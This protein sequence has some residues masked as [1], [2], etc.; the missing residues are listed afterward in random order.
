MRPFRSEDCPTVSAPPEENREG[1][2]VTVVIP[3]FNRT[4]YLRTALESAL[5]QTYSNLDVLVTDSGSTT[6]VL[7]EVRALLDGMGDRRVRLVTHEEGPVGMLQNNLGA[8]RQAPGTYVANL[9]DD[10]AWEPTF[11]ERLVAGLEA[12]P[13]A[14]MAFCDHHLMDTT[15]EILPEA[16]EENTK[17]W[18]R[19]GME[20]GLYSPFY[21]HALV[22]RS[23]PAV[24]GAMYRTDLIDWTDFPDEANLAYDLW[25]AYLASRDGRPAYYVSDRLTRYRTH[26]ESATALQTYSL[27][28]DLVYCYRRFLD[29]DRLSSIRTG[30]RRWYNHYQ[31]GVALHLLSLDRR[32]EA[33]TA[34]WDAGRARWTKRT[35]LGLSLSYLP[36]T[37]LL[38]LF[39]KLK[40][41][42]SSSLG[43]TV[44]R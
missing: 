36:G 42:V 14:S 28:R 5:R 39:R 15:G 16:T 43:S 29:D 26:G 22:A 38:P 1:P 21:A 23:V 32:S 12:H 27:H 37:F 44:N 24:M 34:F 20:T 10:D 33:R 4:K 19:E 31:V 11:V 13:E 2:L 40:L 7:A 30:L 3:V 41:A 18:N 35:L 9:H 17:A 8:M 25:L 6:E